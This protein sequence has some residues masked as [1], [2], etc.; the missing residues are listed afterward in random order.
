MPRRDLWPVGAALLVFALGSPA[1]AA[2]PLEAYGKL[3][4]VE[5]MRLSPDG[6][7][8]AFVA[9]LKEARKLYVATVHG[10][11]L[12]AAP[13]GD[14]KVRG[15]FWVGEDHLLVVT[16]STVNLTLDFG[17]KYELSSVFQVD[18]KTG[19]AWWVFEKASAIA[20]TV[21]GY[22]GQ[23]SADGH[24]YGYFGGITYAR[25]L[26][27]DYV[28]EHGWSDLYRVDLDSGR[29]EMAAHGAEK[30]HDWTVA[31]DGA[32]V[33]HA[34]YDE[35][36]GEW[37]L[38]AGPGKPL[39]VKSAPLA[40]MGLLGLGRTPGTVLVADDT[41]DEDLVEEVPLSGGATQTLFDDVSVDEELYDPVTGLLIGAITREE[42]GA[43][44]FDKTMEARWK[45]TRKAFPGLQVHL[46]SFSS[47]L[48]AM[49]VQ[50]EGPRDAGTYWFVDMATRNA[51]PLGDIHP[52]IK[53]QDVGE[54]KLFQ[55]KAADGLSMDGVLTLPPGREPKALPVVVMP[56]GGPIGVDDRPGFDWWAQAFASRGYAVFQPNFRGSSGHGVDF[57]QAGMGEWGRK[58]Q[59]DI[60]DGLAALAGQGIVDP[61]RACIVGASYGGYAALAGVTLQHGL[62]RCAVSVSGPAN[63]SSFFTWQIDR[64]GGSRNDS[65]RYWRQVTGADKG[66]DRVMHAISP[67]TFAKSADA[68]VLLIHGKDDT[69]VPVEQSRQMAAA[70]KRAGKPVEVIEI[71]GGDH[72]E[73]HEDARMVTLANSVAF[74]LKHNPPG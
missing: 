43:V 66:G 50:T 62:Y 69:V 59:S 60:S 2:P 65:T 26:T 10:K 56:H 74:V 19:K 44:F 7:K 31:R 32:V 16:S 18:L 17:G 63:M 48:D 61:K 8:F 36:S 73:L 67:T 40:D 6:D 11:S 42:P 68:P 38:F 39:L 20:H 58:M 72:W 45:G 41:G 1:W 57:R 25:T 64:H 47:N 5:M 27:N 54:M 9:D 13:I 24:A 4:A 34:D 12:L 52:D 30:D 71:N 55:Y 49:I 35:R 46:V 70:L 33:A 51:T 22:Y 3:P 37:R 21:R 29:T 14:N 23:S 53:P 15:V 28:F